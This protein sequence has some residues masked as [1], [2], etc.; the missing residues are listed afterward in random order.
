MVVHHYLKLKKEKLIMSITTI[1]EGGI[2]IGGGISIGSGSGGGGGTGGINGSL[3]YAE[4]P[5]PI[6]PGQQIE[7]SSAT[8]NNPIGFTINNA[9][10][11]G[12][13][14]VNLTA[15][16]QAFFATYGTGTKTVTWGAGS[17]YSTTTVNL[18][19]NNPGQL[20]FF[21]QSIS[22]PATFNWPVTFN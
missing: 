14:I 13:A 1:I 21:I 11:T 17:S 3:G 16:N 7:D 18:V 22:V 10:A 19:T 4:V 15:S 9:G 8:V 20:V 2:T 6:V 12:V 5:G